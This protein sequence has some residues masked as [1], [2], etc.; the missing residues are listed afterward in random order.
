MN[1][2]EHLPLG[3]NVVMRSDVW[4]QGEGVVHNDEDSCHNAPETG[5]RTDLHTVPSHGKKLCWDCE[6]PENAEEA[7]NYDE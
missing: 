6:W 5:I 3:F 1:D 7:L 2:I 4:P